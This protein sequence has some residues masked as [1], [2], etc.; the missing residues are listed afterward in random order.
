[1]NRTG[2][3]RGSLQNGTKSLNHTE[4]VSLPNGSGLVPKRESI[5]PM[6]CSI[7]H[8]FCLIHVVVLCCTS[9][10]EMHNHISV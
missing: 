2:S 4:H 3:D 6:V 5:Y 8:V 9:L 1:M 7:M 10:Y